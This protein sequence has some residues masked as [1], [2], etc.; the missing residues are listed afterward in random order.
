MGEFPSSEFTF[1]YDMLR[2]EKPLILSYLVMSAPPEN[3]NQLASVTLGTSLEAPGEG[4]T[5]V[6]SAVAE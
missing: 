6:S 2:A 5:D 4:P 3:L 1:W